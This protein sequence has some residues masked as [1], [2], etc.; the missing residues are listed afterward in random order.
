MENKDYHKILKNLYT[1]MDHLYLII[2]K[3]AYILKQK[4]YRNKDKESLKKPYGS[5]LFLPDQYRLQ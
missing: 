1:Y 4:Y 2:T 3:Y 5:V